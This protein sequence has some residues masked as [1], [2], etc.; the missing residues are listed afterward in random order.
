MQALYRT[1][2]TPIE[3]ARAGEDRRKKTNFPT[4]TTQ[5]CVVC[6]L[7]FA[8]LHAR[9]A[10]R[11]RGWS[12]LKFCSLKRFVPSAP[13]KKISN[14]LSKR[15]AEKRGAMAMAAGPAALLI[16]RINEDMNKYTFYRKRKPKLRAVLW[17]FHSRTHVL[18][19]Y[20]FEK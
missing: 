13:R 6:A 8:F 17:I 7:L 19:G 3:A 5:N 20:A 12:W 15:R 16:K 1:F 18:R 10:R 9:I 2:T 4:Y 11:F 14:A